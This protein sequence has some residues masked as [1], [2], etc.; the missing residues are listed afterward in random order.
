[1]GE[2]ARQPPPAA[3]AVTI[4]G[5]EYISQTAAARA[6]GVTQQ[7]VSVA[8]GRGTLD[9]VGLKKERQCGSHTR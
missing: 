6:L 2:H 9:A 3:K 8:R 1:M 5:V 7:V 4:R